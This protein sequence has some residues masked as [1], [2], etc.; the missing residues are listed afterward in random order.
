MNGSGEVVHDDTL[1]CGRSTGYTRPLTSFHFIMTH[2]NMKLL[3]NQQYFTLDLMYALLPSLTHDQRD[4]G[5][6][7]K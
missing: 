4:K 7:I 1:Q 3:S 5:R 6:R 2:Q